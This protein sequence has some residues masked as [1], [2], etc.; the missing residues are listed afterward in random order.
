MNKNIH[1]SVVI[2][3]DVA[4]V[5]SA[6]REAQWWAPRT[7]GTAATGT[8]RARHAFAARI[9]GAE[10][11]NGARAARAAKAQAAAA[12]ATALPATPATAEPIPPAPASAR[13]GVVEVAPVGMVGGS[14]DVLR[15]GVDHLFGPLAAFAPECERTP[16]AVPTEAAGDVRPVSG[17]VATYAEDLA[18]PVLGGV[19]VLGYGVAAGDVQPVASATGPLAFPVTPEYVHGPQPAPTYSL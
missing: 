1:R 8:D 17:H 15:D 4:G 2:A 9:R 3:A 11:I 6:V 7:T 16:A 12:A 13:P 14:P 19:E 5:P 10:A 18:G